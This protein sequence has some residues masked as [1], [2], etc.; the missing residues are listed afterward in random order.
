ML[1]SFFFSILHLGPKIW[2]SL[3]LS[4]PNSTR[5]S[6]KV[7]V[8]LCVT[9]CKDLYTVEPLGTDTSLLRT[10]SYVPT[11]FSYISSKK[12][13]T[14]WTLSNA[15]NGQR[16]TDKKFGPWE[17]I[18]TNVTSLLRTLRDKVSIICGICT[19]SCRQIH[20]H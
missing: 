17:Q 18:H 4:V 20:K 15:D 1:N 8:K 11:K 5:Q 7:W 2:N 6:P 9:G 19:I 10:V 16:T 13:S 14:I 12:T 3:P